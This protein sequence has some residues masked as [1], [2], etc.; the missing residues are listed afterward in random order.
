MET[1]EEPETEEPA[2]SPAAVEPAVGVSR[3]DFLR[4]AGKQAA[5]EAVTTG[6]KL[7]PGGAVAQALLKPKGGEGGDVPR[8]SLFDKLAA[9]K[10]GRTAP[11]SAEAPEEKTDG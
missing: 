11:A 5:Q 9:W 2:A 10:K 8:P 4:R 6:V 3:R 1:V 7:V